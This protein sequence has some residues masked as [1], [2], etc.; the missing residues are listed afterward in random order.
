MI[1]VTKAGDITSSEITIVTPEPRLLWLLGVGI[2]GLGSF[3][4]SQGHLI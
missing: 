3:A 2:V 1:N 4:P